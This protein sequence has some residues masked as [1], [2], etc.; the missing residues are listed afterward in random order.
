[1]LLLLPLL[2]SASAAAA[3][4]AAAA[5]RQTFV[6]DAAGVCLLSFNSQMDVL[7]HVR[8][9][10]AVLKGQCGAAGGSSSS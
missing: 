10:L 9:A 7:G 2:P 8:E 4:A 1:L 3:A 6:F 5:G